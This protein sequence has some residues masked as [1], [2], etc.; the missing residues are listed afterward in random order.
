MRKD[1]EPAGSTDPEV[2]RQPTC[3]PHRNTPVYLWTAMDFNQV[4][5]PLRKLRKLLKSLPENPAPE[6]VHKLR[7]R[8]RRIEAVA[9]ALEPAGGKETKRLLKAIKPVRKAAGGVRDM[10]VLTSNLIHLEKNGSSDSLVRLVEHLSSARSAGVSDL[11]DAVNRWRRMARRELK[12]YA[13]L[14]ESI[15]A[16]KKPVQ[17]EGE[18]TLDSA[19]GSGST[20][21]DLLAEITHWPQCN[22][23]NLHP[24]RLKVKALRYVLQA[25]TGSDAAF[26]GAL[27]KVKDEIGDWH[28]WQQ[29]LEITRSVLDRPQDLELLAQIEY[30]TQQ[31][32]ARAL[33]S[34]NTLRRRYLRAPSAQRKAS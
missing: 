10:D 5:K 4:E 32:L 26:I 16:G 21:E 29:L 34:V 19:T 3:R 24:F 15:A 7:T 23:Q 14:V 11:A 20:D 30:M 33:A 28:D 2:V 6:D 13:R 31:K 18:R 27:G 9:S 12:S 22:G 17:R 1:T 25:S 8:A